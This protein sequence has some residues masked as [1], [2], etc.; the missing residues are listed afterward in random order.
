MKHEVCMYKANVCGIAGMK[1]MC[2]GCKQGCR[3]PAQ[4]MRALY[5]LV[6][7]GMGSAEYDC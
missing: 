5:H 3:K 7:Y 2:A 4:K 6:F 1:C